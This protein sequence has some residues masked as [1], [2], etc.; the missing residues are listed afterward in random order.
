MGRDSA[1]TGRL[2]L[3]LAG[4]ALLMTMLGIAVIWALTYGPLG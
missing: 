1:A 3:G 4:F 2:L